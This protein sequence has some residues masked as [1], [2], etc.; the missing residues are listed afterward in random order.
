MD[1]R[2]RFLELFLRHQHEV[3]AFVA[4]VVR[5]WHAA[6]DVVQEVGLVL[7][8]KFDAYDPRRP[9]GAWARGVAAVQLLK[10]RDRF[11]RTLPILSPGAVEAV[12]RAYD[13]TERREP[14]AA[15]DA[16]RRC[17]QGLPER[18]R[19][20]LRLRYE[21]SLPLER[22]AAAMTASLPAVKKALLRIRARLQDCVR[23]RLAADG[24]RPA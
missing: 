10:E 5:D 8:R 6:D 19:Q 3:R 12:R 17:L 14:A 15:L 18:A 23:Q 16:L 9:F 20:L 2:E 1:D 24:G 11:R 21:E 22:I 13:G 7:W 4:S